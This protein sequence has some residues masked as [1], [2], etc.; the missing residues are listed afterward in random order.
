ML[1][2]LLLKISLEEVSK[3]ESDLTAG[4]SKMV[5]MKKDTISNKKYQR[6]LHVQELRPSVIK[7]SLGVGRLMYAR[8]IR[9]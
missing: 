1:S 2:C 6:T 9:A 5:T 4:N 8:N 7:N 3:V